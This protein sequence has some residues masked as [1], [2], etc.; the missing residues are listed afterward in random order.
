MLVTISQNIFCNN[1]ESI[2]NL[3]SIK[4]S[5]DYECIP[6]VGDNVCNFMW[7]DNVESKVVEVSFID[8]RKCEIMLE[9]RVTSYTKEN[10]RILA[11]AHG[12][13]ISL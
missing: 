4:K 6:R 10:I 13:I 7:E 9:K 12:W 8:N 1:F 2:G 11:E 3:I 5:E